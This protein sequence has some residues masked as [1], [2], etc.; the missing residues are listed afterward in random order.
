MT[1]QQELE[2]IYQGL[3]QLNGANE[4]DKILIKKLIDFVAGLKDEPQKV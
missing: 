2:I 4:T 1:R 3:Q